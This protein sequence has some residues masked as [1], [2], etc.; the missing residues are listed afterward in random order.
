VGVTVSRDGRFRVEGRLDASSIYDGE[1]LWT[2]EKFASADSES[3]WQAFASVYV[4]QPRL[5]LNR[6]PE[7]AILGGDRIDGRPAIKLRLADPE[8]EDKP[9]MTVWLSMLD[10]TESTF[11]FNLLR[12]KLKLNDETWW[13]FD[14]DGGEAFGRDGVPVEMVKQFSEAKDR[15]VMVP[16][17]SEVQEMAEL[18]ALEDE[19]F[20]VAEPTSYA[21]LAAP[22]LPTPADPPSPQPAAD[23][24]ADAS[25]EEPVDVPVEIDGAPLDMDGDAPEQDDSDDAEDGDAPSPQ[26]DDAAPPATQPWSTESEEAA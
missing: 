10:A 5:L 12:A 26:G 6:F 19:V 20:A 3:V 22:K 23:I 21:R 15:Y 7:R 8:H 2:P 9:E 16:R 4:R 14:A 18:D 11:E 25:D 13:S 17:L 1:H 24:E